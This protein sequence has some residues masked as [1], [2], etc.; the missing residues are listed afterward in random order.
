[1]A[2]KNCNAYICFVYIIPVKKVGPGMAVG[3]EMPWQPLGVPGTESPSL[4]PL[5]TSTTSFS[6]HHSTPVVQWTKQQV[7]NTLFCNV[8]IILMK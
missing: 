3:S 6:P 1:M 4:S 2:I 8:I 7:R 5:S